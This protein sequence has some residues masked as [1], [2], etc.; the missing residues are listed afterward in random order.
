MIDVLVLASFQFIFIGFKGTDTM[1]VEDTEESDA[2]E[3]P[4]S[5]TA[6][7]QTTT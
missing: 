2:S 7:I 3:S 4:N 6:I 1:T 5:L